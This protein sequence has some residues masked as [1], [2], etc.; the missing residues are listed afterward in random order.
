MESNDLVVLLSEFEG[1]DGG[2]HR[3]H[4]AWSRLKASYVRTQASTYFTVNEQVTAFKMKDG[5]SILAYWARAKELKVRCR[6]VGI[7][8]ST[9]HWLAG[10]LRGLP[11]PAYAVTVRYLSQ[12]L[13]TL[14]EAHL[15]DVLLEQE[16]AL[17]SEAK[18]GRGQAL[19][20]EGKNKGKGKNQ[21]QGKRIGVDG[22]WGDLGPAPYDHCHGCHIKGHKWTECHKRPAGAV[23]K[24]IQEGK[25]KKQGGSKQQGGRR[26]GGT[27]LEAEEEEDS[28][29]LMVAAAATAA[30]TQGKHG[31]DEWVLDSGASYNFTPYVSDFCTPLEPPLTSMVRV[32]DGTKLLVTGMG[33]VKVMGLDGKPV[34]LTRVH[35]VPDMHTR[36]LSVPHMIACGAAV[37]FEVG[38]CKVKRGSKVILAGEQEG[39]EAGGLFRLTLP[40]IGAGAHVAAISMELA[41]ERLAHAAPSTIKKMVQR[42]T[43]SGLRLDTSQPMELRCLPCQIGK[44]QRLPFPAATKHKSNQ[45]LELVYMDLWGPTRVPTSGRQSRYVLSLL[46][47]YSGHVWSLQ[48]PDKQASTVLSALKT[49][50]AAAER[51]AGASLKSIRSDNGS[52]FMGEVDQWLTSLG[53][54]RQLAAPYSPQQNGRIER[55]HKTLG[56]G[57]R[58]LLLHSG[59]PVSWWGE[60]LRFLVWIRNRVVSKA[61][62]GVSSPYEAWTGRKPDLSLVR[63]WGCMATRLLPPPARGGKLGPRGQLVIHLGVDDRTKGWRVLDPATGKVQVDRN[64]Q[65]MESQTWKS[66][67]SAHPMEGIGV[68]SEQEVLNF[69]PE[70]EDQTDDPESSSPAPPPPHQ[71]APH[72]EEELPPAKSVTFA[73]PLVEEEPPSAPEEGPVDLMDILD[74]DEQVLRSINAL[75]TLEEDTPVPTPADSEAEAV[76]TAWCMT[77]AAEGEEVPDPKTPEEALSGPHAKQWRAGM[78]EEMEAMKKLKVWDPEPVH[79]PPGKHAVDSKWVLKTKRDQQRRVYKHRARLVARGH[80]QRKGADFWD[81]FSHVVKW[82]TVRALLALMAILSLYGEVCDVNNAFLNADLKEEV[83]L[84]Q[85]AGMEDGTNRVY[86][87]RRALYGLKQAPRTWEQELGAYLTQLGFKR[88]LSDSSLYYRHRDG[89]RVYVLVYVDDLLLLSNR[90]E[91]LQGVKKDLRKVYELKELGPISVYLGMQVL[92]DWEARTVTLGLPGYLAGLEKRFSSLLKSTS[93]SHRGCSNPMTPEM[94][95][96]LRQDMATWSEEQATPADR[97]QYMSILGSLMFASVVSARKVD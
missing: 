41:H 37:W 19:Q 29:C 14:T 76:V 10:V 61:L 89:E 64:L 49:W 8:T 59:L 17:K 32:G 22:A 88:T 13:D 68:S 4:E 95:R 71:P 90:E 39:G 50:L 67:H 5:E 46:D 36:L 86:R 6:E 58:T 62:K 93:A 3:V 82:P 38:T 66:W 42:S 11:K 23:P 27:A 26:Q 2:P 31:K 15:L 75:Y 56:E 81:T 55:W 94:M 43:A 33:D 57:L 85:P 9:K 47:D 65:F 18:Q 69:V 44:A 1:R 24:H 48:L 51:Q 97:Q 12:D 70:L 25:A 84:R 16:E 80:T 77:V 35:L 78:Q 34:T 79:L 20:S 52:E 63:T 83:Y 74:R 73:D 7:P 40:I 28:E 92:R 30:S 60:A 87:L 53:V 45:R 54:Q 72:P 21:Q 91:A 96:L